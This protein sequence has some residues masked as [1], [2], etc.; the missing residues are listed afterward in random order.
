MKDEYRLQQA[1]IV[2]NSIRQNCM[3]DYKC[4]K[5]SLN[6]ILNTFFSFVNCPREQNANQAA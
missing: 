2:V 5:A 1:I 4:M 3:Y 6:L